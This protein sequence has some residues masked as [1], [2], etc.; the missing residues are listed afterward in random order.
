MR[1]AALV[2]ALRRGWLLYHL[3]E[4]DFAFMFDPEP[5]DEWVAIDCE[6]T[7]PRRQPRPDRR[8]RRGAHRRATAC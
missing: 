3:A 6:T 2:R 4:P 1:L 5:R 7:G 8:H